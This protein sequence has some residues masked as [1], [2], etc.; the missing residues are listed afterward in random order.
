MRIPSIILIVATLSAACSAP[1]PIDP[2][3]PASLE[4]DICEAVFRHQFQHNASAVQ[5]KAAAYFLEIRKEDPSAELLARFAGNEP[6]VLA[7]SK[8]E[9][10]KGLQFRVTSIEWQ[11]DDTVKVT[12][13]Y[14]EASLSASGNVYTLEPD[15]DSWEVT[16]DE[17]EWIS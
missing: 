1:V 6:P 10:G 7:G 14:S 4:L 13:G 2:P 12:G 15:D 9:I 11:D 16:D 3:D 5:Q 8:F 17:M